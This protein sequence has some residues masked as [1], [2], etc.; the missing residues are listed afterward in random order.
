MNFNSFLAGFSSGSQYYPSN[1]FLLACRSSKLACIGAGSLLSPPEAARVAW[2]LTRLSHAPLM[3][4]RWGEL[5]LGGA[6]GLPV[7]RVRQILC[8]GFT[9]YPCPWACPICSPMHAENNQQVIEK[10]LTARV[11]GVYLAYG[12]H[13]AT[14]DHP[15]GLLSER[16]ALFMGTA[17]FYRFPPLPPDP[18]QDSETIR[19]W[20]AWIESKVLQVKAMLCKPQA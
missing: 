19:G 16:A 13:A 18:A 14:S 6:T 7:L 5:V 11:V 15:A 10:R 9:P 20:L 17:L 8:A 3:L 12:V 2:A 1:P 4:E